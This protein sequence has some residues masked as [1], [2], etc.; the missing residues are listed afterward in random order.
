MP[1]K[2]VKCAV[3]R[4][5]TYYYQ[6][7]EPGNQY[8]PGVYRTDYPNGS[9]TSTAH[10]VWAQGPRG[11]VRI[12]YEDWRIPVSRRFGGGYKTTDPGAMKQFAWIKLTAKDY[13]S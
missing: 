3:A 7:L 2:L 12:I 6:F 5:Y 1:L 13:Q 9:M 10:R 4:L 8:S 11:G